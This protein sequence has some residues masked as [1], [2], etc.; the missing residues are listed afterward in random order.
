MEEKK[1][2][3]YYWPGIP[4]TV[5]IVSK[6]IGID[7]TLYSAVDLIGRKDAMGSESY[8]DKLLRLAENK[9]IDHVYVET[10]PLSCLNEKGNLINAGPQTFDLC[11][12]K[13]NLVNWEVWNK[14]RT[15]RFYR[16]YD[17]AYQQRL[18]YR[19]K[20]SIPYDAD[21]ESKFIA[22]WIG[23]MFGYGVEN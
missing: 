20:N 18:E 15:E 8:Y 7:K 21:E 22:G 5:R 23:R 10:D 6:S 14:E 9:E 17:A 4:E 1:T 2:Y 19:R 12:D 11:E 3:Y 16:E 13:I